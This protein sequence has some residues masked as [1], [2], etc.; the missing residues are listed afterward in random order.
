[1]E[2]ATLLY[3]DSV[4]RFKKCV[5]DVY[6]PIEDYRVGKIMDNFL[7]D[8][9]RKKDQEIVDYNL[10]WSRELLKAEKVAGDLAVKWKAH[11]YLKKMR[12]API[13]KSQVLTGILGDYTVEALQKAA[14]TTFPSIKDAF[15]GRSQGSERS[16]GFQAHGKHPKKPR[17]FRRKQHKA[18]EAHVDEEGEDEES[19]EGVFHEENEDTEGD[20]EAQEYDDDEY[21]DVPE[22]LDEA[23]AEAEAFLTRAKAESGYR[24][25]KRLLQKGCR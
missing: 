20:E 10:A 6:E 12:L 19:D 3:E 1:M 15:T 22:E 2:A 16:A 7:D 9:Y 23:L 11:V 14:L 21:E 5:I 17:F 8:F 18:H 4:E 24:E 25:G 13:P